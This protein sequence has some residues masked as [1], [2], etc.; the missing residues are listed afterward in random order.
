MESIIRLEENN[1]ES[2]K[3]TSP[4]DSTADVTGNNSSK[5]NSPDD[6]AAEIR[7]MI[8]QLKFAVLKKN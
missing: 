1:K 7:Q 5:V 3:L 8:M 6:Y 4:S 2:D